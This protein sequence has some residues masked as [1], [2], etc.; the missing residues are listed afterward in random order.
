[1]PQEAAAAD[2]GAGVT[3]SSTVGAIANIVIRAVINA[4]LGLQTWQ[5]L[6]YLVVQALIGISLL[7]RVRK[8]FG[9]RRG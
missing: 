6:P 2:A 3:W 9:V 4:A 7:D 8:K 1:M 5:I